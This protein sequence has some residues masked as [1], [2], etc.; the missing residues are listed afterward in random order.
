MDSGKDF[1]LLSNNVFRTKT[2][3]YNEKIDFSNIV[4]GELDNDLP[5]D[6]LI[7]IKLPDD[8]TRYRVDQVM[9]N[10]LETDLS[11]STAV[12]YSICLH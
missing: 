10:L 12:P 11:G 1:I 3:K 2:L 7:I 6:S 8:T 4:I 9:S 5:F